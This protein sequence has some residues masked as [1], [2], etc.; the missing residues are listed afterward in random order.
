MLAVWYRLTTV[1]SD[2]NIVL[3]L[4]ASLFVFS[5]SFFF[6]GDVEA[7]VRAKLIE[8]SNKNGKCRKFKEI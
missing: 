8:N 1:M 6:I 2:G 5:V 7:A 3:G 4:H